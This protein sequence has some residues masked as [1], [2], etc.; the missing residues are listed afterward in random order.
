MMFFRNEGGLPM[1]GLS[2]FAVSVVALSA[3]AVVVL[4]ATVVVSSL[5]PS[6]TGTPSTPAYANNPSKSKTA[7]Y[8]MI[9]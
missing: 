7:R 4:A 8:F 5:P 6:G 2:P 9:L 1:P 3:A